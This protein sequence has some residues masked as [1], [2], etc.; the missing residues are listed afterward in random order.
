M[1]ARGRAMKRVTLIHNPGAGDSEHAGD[2]L[3]R[4]LSDAGYEVVYRSTKD[5]DYKKALEGACDLVVAA[6]GDGTVRKVAKRLVGRGVPMSV[7]PLG[8]ANNIAKSL[9]L[10]SDARALVE[11]LK[12]ARALKFD[13]GVAKGPWGTE[14]FFEAFGLGL[15]TDVM[16]ELDAREEREPALFEQAADPLATALRALRDSLPV[17]RARDLRLRLDGGDL[18]GRYLMVEAMNIRS[19]GPNLFLAPDADPSDGLLDFVL[20]TEGERDEFSAYLDYRLDGKQDAPRLTVRRGRRLEFGWD[21]PRLRLDDEAWPE[22][23]RSSESGGPAAVEITVERAGLE[24]L[25]PQS[26]RLAAP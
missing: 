7:L 18:P 8:T 16:A 2:E 10:G 20:L 13:V 22:G 3:S 23:A 6:G 14:Y 25:I 21:G 9:G 15:F 11:G 1:T 24:F 26:E 5:D 17:Y 19:V 4:A 12:S